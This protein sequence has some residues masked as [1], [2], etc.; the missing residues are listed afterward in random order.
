M[1]PS[2]SSHSNIMCPAPETIPYHQ[3]SI[4]MEQP[5]ILSSFRY[6]NIETMRDLPIMDCRR[7]LYTVYYIFLFCP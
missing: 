3:Y 7:S 2:H 6:E 1:T 4:Q 5:P